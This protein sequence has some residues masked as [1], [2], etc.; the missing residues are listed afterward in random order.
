MVHVHVHIATDVHVCQF[1]IQG[2]TSEQSPPLVLGDSTSNVS[3]CVGRGGGG[4][5]S[6]IRM[7]CIFGISSEQ[8]HALVLRNSTDLKGNVC[9]GY[10]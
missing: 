3:V 8:S 7:T 6:C 2:S 10:M 9:P 1:L 4:W 5:V